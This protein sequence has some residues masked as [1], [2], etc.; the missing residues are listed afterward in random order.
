MLPEADLT[1]P[2]VEQVVE[3]SEEEEP[4]DFSEME[5]LEDTDDSD[6]A[7]VNQ[8]AIQSQLQP[9]L[10]PQPSTSMSKVVV[11]REIRS[12]PSME[13]QFA[14]LQLEDTDDEAHESQ[15]SMIP[16]PGTPIKRKKEQK[17]DYS[18][19]KRSKRSL[20]PQFVQ[21]KAVSNAAVKDQSNAAM[22]AVIKSSATVGMKK[23]ATKAAAADV[24]KKASFYYKK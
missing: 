7:N 22:R 24:K 2:E 20:E 18:T 17:I 1:V 19:V 4:A 23:N 16:V 5:E 13:H 9:Q 8:L 14:Q 15:L 10:E 12:K 11:R 6:E 3:S 21:R